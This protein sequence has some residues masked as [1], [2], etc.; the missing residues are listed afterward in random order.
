MLNGDNMSWHSHIDKLSELSQKIAFDIGAIKRIRP[1]ARQI[2]YI[3]STMPSWYNP[4]SINY[5]SIVW[6][7]CGETLSEK[8]Q[9]LQNRAARILTGRYTITFPYLRKRNTPWLIE[10]SF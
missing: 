7:N 1:L 3:T 4:I 5:C 6:G 10:M 2:Y 9:K 8:L